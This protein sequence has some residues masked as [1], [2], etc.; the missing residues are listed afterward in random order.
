MEELTVK[1]VA[2][3]VI[4]SYEEYKDK[5]AREKFVLKL[6]RNAFVDSVNI[7]VDNYNSIDDMPI[8]LHYQM[9]KM[10]EIAKKYH[11]K[12]R[13]EELESLL[14]QLTRL[15]YRNLDIYYR[16]VLQYLKE[17]NLENSITFD[18]TTEIIDESIAK[19][20]FYN[21]KIE[22]YKKE[23]E[24]KNGIRIIL[25]EG[26]LKYKMAFYSFA[27][28]FFDKIRREIINKDIERMKEKIKT[29]S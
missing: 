28:E 1:K 21:E 27:F 3:A 25:K 26:K 17:N 6:G 13:A 15:G 9:R 10:V 11:K 23:E 24:I 14:K 29:V 7:W 19:E 22:M 8:K 2:K 18:I 16:G 5:S 20:T 12:E 4:E